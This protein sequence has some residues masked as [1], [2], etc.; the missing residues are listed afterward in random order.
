MVKEEN[1]AKR[2]NESDLKHRARWLAQ[3]YDLDEGEVLKALKRLPVKVETFIRDMEFPYLKFD[4]SLE[5]ALSF[6]KPKVV[7]ET[8]LN[9]DVKKLAVLV[10]LQKELVGND[11]K[12]WPGVEELCR[13]EA[14]SYLL[15]Y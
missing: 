15:P 9:G 6:A 8:F 12:E 11:L 3:R 14:E 10:K 2:P 13:W 5:E 4:P 7:L 1:L